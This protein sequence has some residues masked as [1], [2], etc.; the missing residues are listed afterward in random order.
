MWQKASAA[1][2]RTT[3]DKPGASPELNAYIKS[4]VPKGEVGANA[5]QVLLV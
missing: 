1:R 2:R 3:M 5:S 4:R